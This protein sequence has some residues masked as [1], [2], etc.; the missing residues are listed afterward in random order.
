MSST[1]AP[2][3]LA[4]ARRGL[5]PG[6]PGGGSRNRTDGLN[7]KSKLSGQTR[8]TFF[9]LLLPSIVLLV[10]INGYPLIYA[11]VQATHDGS[12]IDTGNFVG[13]DNF[14]TVLSSPAFWKAAQFT[15]WFTIV[16]VFGSW[17]VGLGLALLLRTKIPA[18]GTFK[19]LLLLPWVVPI[20]VSSTAWNWLVATPDSLIPS[21]FRNLGLGTPLFLA[22]PHLAAVMV[23]VFKVWVSFPFMMMMISAALASVDTTVYEAASMDGASKWQQFTQITLPMIA[24]STYISWILMTIFCVNDFPTIYLLTGGGPVDATTSLV[25]LA[26]RSVFQDFQTGPGVAIAFLM[27]LTLVVVSVFLYRQIRKSSVE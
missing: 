20:V 27:T 10:L 4:R 6:G 7:R 14:A 25:V 2:S 19:V 18:G 26:Y 3:G 5:A 11:G 8:R 1:T 24:R 13:V 9:W 15:L 22:D 12:L 23:M 21:I 17:L 16:G